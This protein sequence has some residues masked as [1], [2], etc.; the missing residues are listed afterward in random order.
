MVQMDPTEEMRD[1]KRQMKH[2]EMLGMVADSEHGIP[3]RCA[4]GGRMIDEVR[5]KEEHDYLPGKRFFTC[6][7]YQASS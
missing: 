2:I 3:S 5:C 6:T 4:C 1:R 7:N